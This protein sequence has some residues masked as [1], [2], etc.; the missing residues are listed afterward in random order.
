MS[1]LIGLTLG[2]CIACAAAHAW[3]ADPTD[4]KSDKGPKFVKF[5]NLATGKVL[6]V[7]GDAE[8]NESH[9]I[10]I[11]DRDQKDD[12]AK[13]KPS[14]TAVKAQQWKLAKDGAEFKITNRKSS[15]AIDVPAY[16]TDEDTQI[17]AYEE[18]PGPD[19]IDNQRWKLET[20]TLPKTDAKADEKAAEKPAAEKAEAEQK[21]QRI[22]S[23]SSNMVLDVD[24]A[25][26]IVQRPVDPKSKSQLWLIVDV[27]D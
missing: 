13:A 4:T 15:L 25:G 3:A 16:S 10:V 12:A 23:K 26:F 9:L 18:K 1:R 6:A 7:E 14:A 17:I 8:E 11:K 21:P 24:S 27:K 2:L 19:D 5:V 22:R 20:A